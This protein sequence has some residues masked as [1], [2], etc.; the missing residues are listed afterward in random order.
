MAY[1]KYIKKNGKKFGPYYYESYR[2]SSGKIKK[3][4]YLCQSVNQPYCRNALVNYRLN[5]T[6]RYNEKA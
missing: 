5:R 1:K 4:N 3:K 2:D 6:Y